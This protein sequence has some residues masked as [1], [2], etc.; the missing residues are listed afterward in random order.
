M[1]LLKFAEEAETGLFKLKQNKNQKGAEREAKRNKT[2]ANT[3]EIFKKDLKNSSQNLQGQKQQTKA[4]KRNRM[5][6]KC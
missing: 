6:A 2:V 1:T 5:A 3:K 4:I